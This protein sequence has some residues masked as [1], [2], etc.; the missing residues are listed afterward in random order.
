MYQFEIRQ[1]STDDCAS[2]V[3]LERVCWPLELQASKNIIYTRFS[4]GHN[5]AGILHENKLIGLCAYVY[6]DQDPYDKDAFPDTFKEFASVPKRKPYLSMYIYNLSMHP[7]W[8]GK[9]TVASTIVSLITKY[10]YS[11]ST[12]IQRLFLISPHLLPN[13]QQQPIR[14][15]SPQ[16][17]TM[18]SVH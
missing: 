17:M 12:Q 8:R 7:D 5:F 18:R 1:L 14:H 4:L 15:L 2:I 11:K 13:Y 10:K 16:C 9:N 3:E 6:T